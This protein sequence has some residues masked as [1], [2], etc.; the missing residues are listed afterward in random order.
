MFWHLHIVSQIVWIRVCFLY[1]GKESRAR[2]TSGPGDRTAPNMSFFPSSLLLLVLP[3]SAACLCS[4]NLCNVL[5]NDII[6]AVAGTLHCQTSKQYTGGWKNG[7][8]THTYIMLMRVLYERAVQGWEGEGEGEGV[9]CWN[10][11]KVNGHV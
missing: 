5:N 11:S 6:I 3:Q 1:R 4:T 2:T 9:C 8:H 7:L 10:E